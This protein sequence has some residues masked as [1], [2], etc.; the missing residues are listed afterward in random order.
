VDRY[1]IK[2][3]GTFILF[4]QRKP[5]RVYRGMLALSKGGGI[6]MVSEAGYTIQGEKF[7]VDS[8]DGENY[9]INQLPAESDNVNI[10]L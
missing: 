7:S 6:K 8:L 10:Q 3:D 5:D 9:Q 2:N 4:S 1:Q